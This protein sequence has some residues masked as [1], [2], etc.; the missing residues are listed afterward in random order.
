M[1][2]LSIPHVVICAFLS[3][4]VS[5]T[6][7]AGPTGAIKKGYIK[8]DQGEKCWYT[9]EIKENYT[10]F[11]GPLKET[12]GIITF[13]NPACMSDSGA[14]L[15]VNKMM[16]NNVISKWYSRSDAKFK[17]RVSEMYNGSLLQEK[18]KC[19]QSETYPAIGITVDYLINDNSIAGV[20]HG[21]S[22]QGCTN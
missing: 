4:I 10:Y 22:V 5:A 3:T 1:K 9:Q 13:D 2:F 21:S 7:S 17:T 18:G 16:I 12:N 11:H 14:G 15:D 6:V 19:I 8:N 20:I